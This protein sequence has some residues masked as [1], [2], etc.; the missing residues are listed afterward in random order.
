MTKNKR[1][2]IAM[3]GGVDSA[4]AAALLKEQGYSVI[5]MTM[6]VWPKTSCGYDKKRACCSLEGITDARVVSE[7]LD[8]PYYVIDLEKE[9]RKNVIDYFCKQ[10]LE[11]ITPNP[12]IVCNEKMKFGYLLNSAKKLN[13]NL[14]A[15]GHHAKINY[16]KAKKRYI[17]RKGCDKVKDQSYFLF[18]LPQERLSHV[19]FPIGGLTKKKVRAL[20]K[21]LGLMNVYKKLSSQEVC[22]MPDKNFPRFLKDEMG[23]DVKKGIIVDGNDKVLGEHKGIPFYTIGQRHGLGIA[24]KNPLYVIKIDKENNKIIVG[25]REKLKTK[26]LIASDVNWISLKGIDKPLKVWAK[27]RY[28]HKASL[29]V[30]KKMKNKEVLVEFKKAQDAVTPGQAVVFYQKDIVVGGGWIKNSI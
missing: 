18:N 12:C 10:Y 16:D 24:H 8:I 6:K 28:S 15:T 17:L 25:E 19:L 30:V 13:A 29:A 9:F 14:I 7:K 27:I 3:S 1:I 22:F 26:A 11:G 5:G 4:V 23:I 2:V 20:A 21:K